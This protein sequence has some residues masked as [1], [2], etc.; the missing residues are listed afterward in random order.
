MTR[1]ERDAGELV[2]VL[3]CMDRVAR[4]L[5]DM[6]AP[7][8]FAVATSVADQTAV[9]QLRYRVSCEEGWL[10]PSAAPDGLE[11][12]DFDDR[13]IHL[14][15]WDD[16]TLA[17]TARLVLPHPGHRLPTEEAFEL[18]IVP[19]GEVVDLGRGIVAPAYRGRGHGVFFGLLAAAWLQ[20]R[21]HGFTQ[22]CGTTAPSM[23]PNYRAMGFHVE[24][25][26]E[27]RHWWGD[28]R[29]PIKMDGA[30]CSEEL[31]AALATR[32]T[33]STAR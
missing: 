15:G 6:T 5:L 7:V 24:V 28:Q 16:R 32:G 17:A 21:A 31:L 4:D 20:A 9:Y 10:E 1:D 27:A 8:R 26:G 30:R 3:E 2:R 22:L 18:T 23:L 33:S 25:L 11:K 19:P 14:V 12:D 13:A 29:L